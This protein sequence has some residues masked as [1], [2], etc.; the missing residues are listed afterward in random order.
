MAEG[1]GFDFM[2]MANNHSRDFGDEGILQ[3]ERA[4]QAQGMLYAVWKGASLRQSWSA[5]DSASDCVLSGTI[6]T[7]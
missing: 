1:G 3:T 2:S 6:P 5:R 4:L 7:P